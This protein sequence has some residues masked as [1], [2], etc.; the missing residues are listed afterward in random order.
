MVKV[1][2]TQKDWEER[3]HD[4]CMHGEDQRLVIDLVRLLKMD[5]SQSN[6]IQLMVIR[7]LVSKLQKANNH[8]YVDLVK[9]ISGLFKNE[10]GPTNYSLLAE[11][12]G[13]ARETTAAKHSIQLRL[14]PGLNL[15]SIDQAALTFKGLPVNEASDGA[16]CLRYLEPR[17]Q[18]DGEVVLVGHVWN[19]DVST[20][21]DQNI[22][23][24][25]RDSKEHNQDDFEALK[26]LTDK[27]IEDEKLAKTVSIHN[28]TPPSFNGEFYRYKLY[29]AMSGS[30]VQ[31]K[32]SFKV[33][34]GSQ[35]SLL[36]RQFRSCSKSTVEFG[37][38]FYRF[39][40]VLFSSCNSAYDTNTR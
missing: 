31:S 4:S 11:I 40:R 28:L 26:R 34:G 38:L 19:P 7:N 9:D 6:P 18:N 20:W 22:H 37:R 24:P 32:A 12:F 15:D 10:L 39:C 27:L 21:H 13:L 36:L 14:D 16:R 8:H 29:M 17:K 25:R 1:I 33:L 35:K 3:L 23:I 2:L 5:I 30:R